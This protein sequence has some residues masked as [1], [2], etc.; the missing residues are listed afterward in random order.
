M[1]KPCFWHKTRSWEIEYIAPHFLTHKPNHTDLASSGM[2]LGKAVFVISRRQST[3]PSQ[4]SRFLFSVEKNRYKKPLHCPRGGFASLSQYLLLLLLPHGSSFVC[5]CS[6]LTSAARHP[7]AARVQARLRIG[8]RPQQS[9][10]ATPQSKTAT[11]CQSCSYFTL[12]LAG[13]GLNSQTA[14]DERSISGIRN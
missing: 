7:T 2:H 9:H 13:C 12:F 10:K 3:A 6:F 5:F 14:S 4:S 11:H 1:D 8:H